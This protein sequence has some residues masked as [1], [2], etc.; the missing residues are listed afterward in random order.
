MFMILSTLIVNPN[1]TAP[2]LPS[3]DATELVFPPEVANKVP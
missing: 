2:Y 3:E 1:N